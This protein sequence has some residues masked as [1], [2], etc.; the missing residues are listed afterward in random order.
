MIKGKVLKDTDDLSK[1]GLK[2]DM[3]IMMMGTSED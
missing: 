2:N 1:L 3:Q